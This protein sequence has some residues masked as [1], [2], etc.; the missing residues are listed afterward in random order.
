MNL[1]VKSCV[2]KALSMHIQKPY[3][4]LIAVILSR[5]VFL[6]Q[7]QAYVQYGYIEYSSDKQR[8]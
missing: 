4:V 3:L 5:I 6:H 1:F 2:M 7:T 8:F